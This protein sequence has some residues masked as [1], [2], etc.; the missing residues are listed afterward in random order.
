MSIVSWFNGISSVNGWI[1]NTV[2]N[3]TGTNTGV[4]SQRC[5]L[6]SDPNTNTQKLYNNAYITLNEGTNVRIVSERDFGGV[7]FYNVEY[8]LQKLP[9]TQNW[10]KLLVGL[11]FGA[12]ITGVI[13]SNQNKPKGVKAVEYK[14]E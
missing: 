2:V 12:I 7:K 1:V 5:Y 9:F 10:G 3:K 4:I 8:V 13:I 11:A 6:L 14:G